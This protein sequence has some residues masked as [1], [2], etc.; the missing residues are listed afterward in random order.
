MSASDYEND[1][2]SPYDIV[3]LM[4]TVNKAFREKT[5]ITHSIIQKRCSP[6]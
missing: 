1:A 6:R 3:A 5:G 2:V 4:L